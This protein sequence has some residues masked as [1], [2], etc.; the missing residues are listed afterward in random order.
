[1]SPTNITEVTDLLIIQAIAN[2][3]GVAPPPP[4][5][6][7]PDARR[8][9]LLQALVDRLLHIQ[10]L[11]S[12]LL[13]IAALA[14]QPFGRSLLT[15]ADAA[16]VRTLL[17][18]GALAVLGAVGTA[19]INDNSVTLAKLQQLS[20]DTLLGRST[21]GTGNV[22][23][24]TCTAVGRSLLA[25]GNASAA[26]TAISAAASTDVGDHAALVQTHGVPSGR[27]ILSSWTA[28]SEHLQRVA[29]QSASTIG[30]AVSLTHFR[31]TSITFGSAFASTPAILVCGNSGYPVT[32]Y[33]VAATGFS[34]RQ[35]DN[36]GTGAQSFNFSFIAMGA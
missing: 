21:A 24:V 10:P 1:M 31:D 13:A 12:D 28:S 27:R 32:A 4:R 25:A 34:V 23:T 9:Q 15:G 30:N 17:G 16:A 7:N 19:Q 29:N 20:T 14:T 3:G 6:S 36:L 35:Y 11:D 8:L 33:S 5:P 22:E 26:R 18:L 2:L